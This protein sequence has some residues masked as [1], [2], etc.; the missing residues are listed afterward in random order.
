MDVSYDI[1]NSATWLRHEEGRTLIQTYSIK[2][3]YSINNNCTNLT[4]MVKIERNK[5]F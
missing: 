3:F 2:M 1:H 5:T 4:K